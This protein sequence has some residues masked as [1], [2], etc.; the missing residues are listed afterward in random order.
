MDTV[1]IVRESPFG[2]VV[3]PSA[4]ARRRPSFHPFPRTSSRGRTRGSA[5]A[6]PDEFCG[7]S[8]S[9]SSHFSSRIVRSR[10]PICDRRRAS[11]PSRHDQSYMKFFCC[12]SPLQKCAPF[13]PRPSNKKCG[14]QQP[15][16]RATKIRASRRVPHAATRPFPSS[17]RE[18]SSSERPS[19]WRRRTEPT[20][21]NE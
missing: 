9:S 3:I 6:S 4:V 20:T 18:T 10:A 14:T 19:L 7:W 12:S 13:V 11:S 17:R 5:P 16:N 2:D 1:E 15:R 21:K 8:F